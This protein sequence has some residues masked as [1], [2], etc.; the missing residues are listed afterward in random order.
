MNIKELTQENVDKMKYVDFISMLNETNRPPGGKETIR[1]IAINTFIDR[2]S[3]ILEIGCN[4][5][6]SSFEIT[7]LTKCQT[8]GT[9][10]NS[11]AIEQA[12]KHLIKHKLQS[13]IKF[14]LVSAE[15]LP[16]ANNYFDLIISGGSFAWMQNK[17]NALHESTR[18]LKNWGFLSVV[19][20]YYVSDP[21]KNLLRELS[22]TLDMKIQ[23]WNKEYWQSFFVGSGLELYKTIDKQLNA[24][25]L[26]TIEKYVDKITAHLNDITD[27]ATIE[28]IKQKAINYYSLFNENHK[29]LAYSILLLRKRPIEEQIELF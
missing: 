21:P 24:V 8:I 28:K 26:T 22:L 29:Y 25:D 4:T 17:E 14:Q 1:E 13:N 9:D 15:K 20:M 12:R 10:I 18:V 5:G 23:N 2:S 7:A 27:K 16:Y 11:N 3:V 6:F 19:P